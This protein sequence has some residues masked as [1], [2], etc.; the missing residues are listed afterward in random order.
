MKGR[1]RIF[2][3]VGTIAVAAIL[4]VGAEADAP[5]DPWAAGDTL[6]AGN[7]AFAFDLYRVLAAAGEQGRNA[8][9]LFVSPYS[10]SSALAMAYAGARGQTA[11]QMEDVLQFG[12]THDEVPVMFGRLVDGIRCSGCG[13]PWMQGRLYELNTA[14]SLWLQDGYSVLEEFLDTLAIDYEAP[15]QL[16]DFLRDPDGSRGAIN[17]WVS[18]ETRG[19]IEDLLSPGVI[20]SATR[21]ILVNA[22]Y[23]YAGWADPFSTGRTHDAPFALLDEEVVFVPTMHGAMAGAYVSLDGVEVID[24]PFAGGNARMTILLPE[25]GRFEQVERLLD[26]AVFEAYLARLEWGQLEI[27]LPKFRVEAKSDLSATL[28][29]MG[30]PD[31]FNPDTADFSGMDG[32]RELHIGKV[33]HQAFVDVR[34][35]GTE[36]A[37]ATAVMMLGTG[38]PPEPIPVAVDRPFVFVIREQSTGTILF[39]GRVLDP[40]PAE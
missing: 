7:T 8:E 35:E 5:I 14:N 3:L 40:R 19:T 25:Q 13:R 36:A 6:V 21:M 18:R 12:L 39:V 10:V 34:E 2:G 27:A 32:S 15:A 26:A 1:R 22:I 17:G 38:I 16:V 9:N 23:F 11:Q 20:T 31:A 28:A 29:S 37:A 30:M 24:L 4:A 33:I